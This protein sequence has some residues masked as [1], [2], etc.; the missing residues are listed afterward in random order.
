MF[1]LLYKHLW[2]P[3]DS[4]HTHTQTDYN[5]YLSCACTPSV[6]E[7]RHVDLPGVCMLR[8]QMYECP[9]RSREAKGEAWFELI[10]SK[11]KA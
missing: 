9:Q 6:N 1:D 7:R 10:L 11:E 8:S 5:N 4:G 2:W 3:V